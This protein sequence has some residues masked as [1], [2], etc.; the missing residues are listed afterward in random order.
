M[1]RFAL[2]FAALMLTG[3]D[4]TPAGAMVSAVMV[5]VAI[6]CLGYQPA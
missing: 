3:C 4:A 1:T 2:L 5:A 6:G